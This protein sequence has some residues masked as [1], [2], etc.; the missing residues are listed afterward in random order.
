MTGSQAF[1]GGFGLLIQI[2]AIWLAI[3]R[4][5][6]GSVGAAIHALIRAPETGAARANIP[7]T[8]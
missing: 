1:D 3:S 6:P 5:I 8:K 4:G 2:P 7:E